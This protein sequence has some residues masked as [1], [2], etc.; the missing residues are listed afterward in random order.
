MGYVVVGL[1]LVLSSGHLTKVVPDAWIPEKISSWLTGLS[2]TGTQALMVMTAQVLVAV[3]IP[4]VAIPRETL[5]RV[6]AS[7]LE[8]LCE[9]AFNGNRQTMRYT[10]FRPAGPLLTPAVYGLLV[11]RGLWRIVRRREALFPGHPW[12]FRCLK[13]VQRLGTEHQHSR[14]F[15]TYSTRRRE[16]G[17]GV[18]ARVWHLQE[19]ITA[20]NLPLVTQQMIANADR[21]PSHPDAVCV[22]AYCKKAFLHRQELYRLNVLSRH[23]HGQLLFNKDGK[24]VAV[25]MIDSAQE[26]NPF[27]DEV[28]RIVSHHVGFLQSTF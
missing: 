8:Q 14:T 19:S 22:E 10:V 21:D 28:T 16:D 15:L 11:F 4:A 17:H 5:R 26:M 1:V 9:M 18:A 25:L 12:S 27:S 7:T 3:I 23:F 6:R 13:I 20:D 24:K 2:D